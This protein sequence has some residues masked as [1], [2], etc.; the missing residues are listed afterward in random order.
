MPTYEYICEAC[1]HEFEKFQSITAAPIK[2]C[3]ICGKKKVVRKISAGGGFIFK[4]GG[5]YE[6]DYRS[7]SYK[8]SAEADKP[9]A[10]VK[11]DAKPAEAKA[12][13]KPA[14]TK[15]VEAK[16]EP[17][18]SAS[19]SASKSSPKSSSKSKKK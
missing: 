17:K 12:E 16:S 6:T 14:E 8:K 3:P 5:F 11:A 1:K 2:A 9:A 10:D 18:K 15:P 19:K 7:E 13:T 4:G